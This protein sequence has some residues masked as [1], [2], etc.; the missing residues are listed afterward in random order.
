MFVYFR[1]L[2]SCLFT[3]GFTYV[4]IYFRVNFVFSH[5]FCSLF[6][7]LFIFIVSGL[8]MSHTQDKNFIPNLL[9]SASRIF[10]TDKFQ[11]WN[12]LKVARKNEGEP[13]ELLEWFE[14]YARAV[15]KTHD[16]VH[17]TP[18]DVV[19]PNVVFGLDVIN[20]VNFSGISIPK[21]NNFVMKKNMFD[22]KTKINLQKFT[23]D[24]AVSYRW[25]GMES[26]FSG[27]II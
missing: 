20:L 2:L 3:F 16:S 18:F 1:V 14:R 19:S 11:L 8:D 6:Y 15:A 21:Y 13:E 17:T 24:D 25:V 23:F 10:A 9:E 4:F 7:H 26:I 22:K 5:S 12:E 27:K